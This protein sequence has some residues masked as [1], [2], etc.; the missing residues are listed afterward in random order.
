M[1]LQNV[2]TT[3]NG[4]TVVELHGRL[5][6]GKGL[7]EAE[8]ELHKIVKDGCKKLVVELSSLDYIDSASLGM[9]TGACSQI[10]AAGGSMRLAGAHGVPARVFKMIHMDKIMPVDENLDAALAALA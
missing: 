5:A 1:S 2:R 7:A 10:T 8:E 4:I 3:D 9:L 6:L